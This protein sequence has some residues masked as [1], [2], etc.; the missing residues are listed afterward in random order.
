MDVISRL[1]WVSAGVPRDALSIFPQA[2]TK[3]SLAGRK[4]VSVSNV[5]VA[6]SETVTQKLRDLEREIASSDQDVLKETLNEIRDFCVKQQKK[7]RS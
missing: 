4:R 6:A 7:I 3:A 5:N 2:M 1:V